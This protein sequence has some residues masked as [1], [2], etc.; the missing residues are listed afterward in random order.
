MSTPRTAP[1]TENPESMAELLGDCHRTAQH[2]SHSAP[3]APRPAHVRPPGIHV[4]PKSVAAVRD[5]TEY[6]A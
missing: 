1:Y 4:P 6:G 2:W 3:A 5:M